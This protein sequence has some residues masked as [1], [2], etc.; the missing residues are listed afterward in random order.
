M[1]QTEALIVEQLRQGKERAYKFLYDQHYQILCHVASQYVKDDFLAETIVGDVIFHLWDVRQALD[2]TTSIRS[3]LMQSVRNRCIDYLKSQYNQC[4]LAMSSLGLLD[5]PV[6]NY[7]KGDDYPLGRL[8]EQELEGE[9]MKAVG[10]LPDECR[11]VFRLSRFEER[12]YEEIA[13]ELNISVNTVKYHIKRAL[14]LLHEDL[15]KYLTAVILL[16][17]EQMK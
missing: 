14:A 15:S 4:E 11:R 9:I 6:I 3:Y 8:L 12:K 1:E 2:I 10:R 5:F 16:L 17:L 7:I 13:K